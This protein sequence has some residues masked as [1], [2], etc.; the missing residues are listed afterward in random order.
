MLASREVGGKVPRWEGSPVGCVLVGVN[1]AGFP[2][3]V[4]PVGVNSAEG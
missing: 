2:Q 1:S 4:S 3:W